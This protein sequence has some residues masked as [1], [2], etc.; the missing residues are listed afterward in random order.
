MRIARME[1]QDSSRGSGAAGNFWANL[2]IRE[3]AWIEKC[4]R[5]TGARVISRRRWRA[6]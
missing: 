2:A 1:E 3:C 5:I 6:G 4:Q